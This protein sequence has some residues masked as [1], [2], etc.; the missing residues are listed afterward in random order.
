MKEKNRIE[1]SVYNVSSNMFLYS[2]RSIM[3][4]VVRTIF[5]KVLGKDILGLDGLYTNILSMLSITELG[6][7][8]AVSFSLYKPLA[9]KNK[10]KINILMSFYKR[11]YQIIGIIVI[12]IGLLIVPFLPNI[13][14]NPPKNVNIYIIYLIYLFN[15]CNLYFISYKEILIIADQ[16]NYK[17]TK[18]NFIFYMLLYI[19]QIVELL[20]FKSYILYIII[21]VVVIFIQRIY[22]NRFIS[23][24]YENITFD[25]DDNLPKSDLNNIK[26]NVKGLMFYKVG[27]YL[28][29]GTDNIIISKFLN[30]SLVGIYTNY[31]SVITMTQTLLSSA[32]KGI[33]SSFGNLIATNTKESQVDAFEKIN[34]AG[35]LLY[36]F[37][38]IAF[39]CLL[40]YFMKLWLGNDFLL[41]MN[42]VLVLCLNFYLDGMKYSLDSVKDASGTY[43]VDKY[44]PLLQAI[45]N[46]VVSV[47]LVIKFGIFGV[48]LG[49][50]ISNI[51]L[52]CWNKPYIVYKY[53]FNTSVKRYYI[54][55]LKNILVYIFIA[56]VTYF[57]ISHINLKL[58]LLT[59]VL[60][61]LIYVILY[62]ILIFI[63]YFKN[64]NFKFYLDL[65]KKVIKKISNK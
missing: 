57:V 38:S 27:N 39:I 23:K 2:I 35:H 28:V 6:I 18:I 64:D 11:A 33:T 54:N 47:A 36:S 53:V 62:F 43:D 10:K 24:Q 40:N 61:I 29:N 17:L 21:Q 52:P 50:I 44:V 45:I 34:F 7:S 20:I 5:I 48:V 12:V 55:Y 1:K 51:V 30:L 37:V 22:I 26:K 46:I 63:I 9:D 32:Y 60:Y 42:V 25:S 16:N 59:F 14:N 19:L 56:F 13:I 4:F 3:L 15:T 31:L 8:Q 65:F 49:T 58:S 41:E